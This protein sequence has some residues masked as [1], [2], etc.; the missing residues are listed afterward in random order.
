[1]AVLIQT[2][3][4]GE[5]LLEQLRNL[6]NLDLQIIELTLKVVVQQNLML[7]GIRLNITLIIKTYYLILFAAILVR[8]LAQISLLF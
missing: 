2:L 5:V 7:F 1:L 3:L 8:S 4:V 6:L